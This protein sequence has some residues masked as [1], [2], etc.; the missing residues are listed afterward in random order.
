MVNKGTTVKQVRKNN[1]SPNYSTILRTKKNKTK[2]SITQINIES[3][4]NQDASSLFRQSISLII[5]L[6]T[7]LAILIA[8]DLNQ[9]IVK[10][11][12][13]YLEINN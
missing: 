10:P 12:N 7:L 5:I 4:L 13:N 2:E 9:N 6:G 8:Y 3:N 11:R 1:V